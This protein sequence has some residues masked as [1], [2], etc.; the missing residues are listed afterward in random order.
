MA[1]ISA[2][3]GAVHLIDL[4]HRQGNDNTAATAM[5]H[6]V[7]YCANDHTSVCVSIPVGPERTGA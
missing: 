4:I 5:M 1:S 2:Q 3:L 7:L 6:L